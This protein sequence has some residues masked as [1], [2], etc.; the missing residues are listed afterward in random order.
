MAT[1]YMLEC[2]DGTIYTGYT[3]DIERRVAA[4]NAG[5]GA[6]YTKPRLPVRLLWCADLPT[7][8]LAR[9]AEVYIKQLGRDKKLRLAAGDVQLLEV[10]PKLARVYEEEVLAKAKDVEK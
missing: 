6:K 10:C 7:A 9:A 2:A 4:H 8:H 3:F 1:V 5:V